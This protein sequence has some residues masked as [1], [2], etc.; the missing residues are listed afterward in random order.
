MG[1]IEKMQK[2][3]FWGAFSNIVIMLLSFAS[4]TVFIYNL[5]TTELGV[6]GVFSNILTILSFAELGIGTAMN[7]SLYGLVAK[8]DINRIKSLM[9]FYKKAYRIIAAIVGVLGL[10][11]VPFLPYIAKGTQGVDHLYA[12]YF[13]YL[14]NT[15]ASYFVSYKYSLSN[16][17]QK[18][19]VFTNINLVF[20]IIC[21]CTQM[22]VV[23]VFKSFLIYCFVGAVVQLIQNITTNIYMNKMYPYLKDKDVEPVSK[24]ELAP[25]I[26]NVKAL[27]ISKIGSICVNQTDN[28][29]ISMAIN[30]TVVGV[31]SNYLTLTRNVGQFLNLV[32]NSG[33]AS[34]GN[35]IATESK[36]KQYDMF[37]AFRFLAFWAYG[38]ASIA[39][40]VLMTPFVSLLWGEHNTIGFA[41]VFWLCVNYYFGGHRT[42]VYNVKVAGGL[43]DQDK[44]LAFAT[45][46]VNLVV[47]IIGAK[48]WGPAGVYFGTFVQG[49][50][51]TIVR[52]GI[53]YKNLFD[54]PVKYYFIDGFKYLVT[55]I[56]AAVMCYGLR[57]LTMPVFNILGFILNMAIVVV[58]PN[59]IFYILFRK[60]PEFEYLKKIVLDK[61]SKIPVIKKLVPDNY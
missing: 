4:R 25:V 10:C 47:S 42:C 55:V 14:F 16:A 61:A 36:Q 60:R 3:I 13:L 52:P 51:E 45:A 48:I 33:T 23:I 29:I 30:V 38:F 9:H 17:E 1:R 37:K 57:L 44:F 5:S 31:I 7:F 41:V 18:N 35:L 12:I 28:L 58:I 21:T 46:I 40:L 11:L 43:F 19:Y 2:N 8:K 24:E 26:K 54:V 22:I 20:N 6:N 39:L 50:L 53:I 34:F 59:G 27:I 32:F 49:M 15:V 56:V